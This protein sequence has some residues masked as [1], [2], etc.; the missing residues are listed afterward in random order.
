MV[1]LF[2]SFGILRIGNINFYFDSEDLP[3]IESRSWYV[4]KDGYLTSSYYYLG[5]LRIVR[6]HRVVVHAQPGQWVDHKDRN[7]ANN[8]KQNLRCCDYLE[9]RG[10]SNKGSVKNWRY[11]Y[12]P[13]A[14]GCS[15]VSCRWL[16][17]S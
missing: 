2:D 3:L 5:Q 4:D 12:E 7:R 10:L 16:P 15:A 14:F 1:E 6:F 11:V 8:R 13:V 17:V 9:N